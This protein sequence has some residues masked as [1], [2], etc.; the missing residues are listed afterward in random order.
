MFSNNGTSQSDSIV[1]TKHSY[2]NLIAY[3]GGQISLEFGDFRIGAF[4]SKDYVYNAVGTVALL[5]PG[6]YTVLFYSNNS[7]ASGSIKIIE[8]F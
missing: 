6:T 1:L 3:Q 4:A 2:V 7:G 5:P 8:L